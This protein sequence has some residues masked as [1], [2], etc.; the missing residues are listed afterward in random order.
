M[1][2]FSSSEPVDPHI[3]NPFKVRLTQQT[4][5]YHAHFFQ[6]TTAH[7]FFKELPNNFKKCLQAQHHTM[8]TAKHQQFNTATTYNNTIFNKT[9]QQF[10]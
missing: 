6:L 7:Y 8:T 3:F 10:T 4:L 9:Q 5:D 2:I 1:R